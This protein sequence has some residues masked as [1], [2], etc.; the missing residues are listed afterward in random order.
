[1]GHVESAGSGAKVLTQRLTHSAL[2][3]FNDPRAGRLADG[4]FRSWWKLE[5]VGEGLKPMLLLD[6]GD[7]LMV[8]KTFGKGKVILVGSTASPVWN[9]LPMQ[10]VWVP[11]VQRVVS[12]LA[13]Q[14]TGSNA[15]VVGQSVRFGL[16]SGTGEEVFS[17]AKPDGKTEEIKARKETQ[18][19]TVESSPILTPGVYEA[20]ASA[21]GGEVKKFAFNVDATES[22]LKPLVD[23]E[24][25]A[26]ASRW[27]ADVVQDVESYQRLDRSRR[28]GAELWQI[29][30]L[31]LL[32]FLFVEV[33]LEQRIAKP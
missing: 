17:L 3:Y 18:G 21:G 30:L 13:T 24:V 28:F 4:E 31:L 20:Q 7:A 22:G 33:L 29:V 26:L 32:L 12:Y 1:M 15:S 9:N 16:D 25:S 19:V 14:G 6:S 2:S 5:A 27:E 8:E 23:S 10:P 11:L